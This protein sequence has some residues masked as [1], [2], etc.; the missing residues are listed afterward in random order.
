MSRKAFKSDPLPF[1]L[2]AEKYIEG[3]RMQLPVEDVVKEPYDLRKIVEFTG[4]ED[5]KAMVDLS[6]KGDYY[7]FIPAKKFIVEVDTNLVVANGTV[8]PYFRNR[9][10]SPMI[11][12]FKGETFMRKTIWP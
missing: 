1:T 3:K 2:P 6:G 11:W 8:K 9:M 4:S 10:V 5:R 12:T 7:N